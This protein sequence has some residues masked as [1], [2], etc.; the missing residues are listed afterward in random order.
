MNI[1]KNI[2]LE[3]LTRSQAAARGGWKNQP[4]KEQTAYLI[5]LCETVLQPLRDHIGEPLIITSGFRS[6]Q[7]NE[8]EGGAKASAHLDGRAA[9][10]HAAGL[11]SRELA[12][13]AAVLNL[14]TDQIINEYDQWVHVSI[15]RAGE[16]PKGDRL[17]ATHA[18]GRTIYLRGLS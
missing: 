10:I 11:S 6:M 14:A 9:D 5:K 1:T 8:A 16:K 12:R 7:T 18:Q 3:E 17:Y 15:P 2:T 13:I 4:N